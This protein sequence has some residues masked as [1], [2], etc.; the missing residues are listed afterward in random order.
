MKRTWLPQAGAA[1]LL[2]GALNPHNPYGY[3]VL[4]RWV[5]CGVFLFLATRAVAT[6]RV[7]WAWVFGFLAGLYN[8]IFKVPLGR[9]LW[10][11]VNMATILVLATSVAVKPLRKE[12]SG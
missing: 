5:C 6:K 11:L 10:V 1:L 9:D 7:E 2:L 4:L 12:A 8:P 3:Y